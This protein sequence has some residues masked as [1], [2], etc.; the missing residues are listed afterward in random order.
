MT[1][2]QMNYDTLK[3]YL[4]LL[5]LEQSKQIDAESIKKQ[6][7]KLAKIYH[8]DVYK[9]DPANARNYIRIKE[10]YE[11]LSKS[12]SEANRILAQN[13]PRFYTP[14][15][16]SEPERKRP[17]QKPARTSSWPYYEAVYTDYKNYPLARCRWQRPAQGSSTIKYIFYD[18]EYS[19]LYIIFYSSLTTVY[20]YE[21][22][23]QSEF[24]SFIRSDSLGRYLRRVIIP[25]YRCV[26]MYP[27]SS[28]FTG[29]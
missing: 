8:P 18:A 3:Q 17:R 29:L 28:C 2:P 12:I 26:K 19:Y 9:G 20:C 23:P 14:P 27:P 11:L 21:D 16:Q 24:N 15:R 7:R 25:N 4:R 1:T 13:T 22:L 10:A 6:Y 5:E